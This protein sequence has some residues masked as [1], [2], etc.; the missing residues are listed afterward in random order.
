M[1]E[2]KVPH[3]LL[4]SSREAVA[5][6][7]PLI[8]YDRRDIYRHYDQTG[9]YDTRDVSIMYYCVEVNCNPDYDW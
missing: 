2:I 9:N 8:R 1:M 7:M 4:V 3:N 6:H 5:E